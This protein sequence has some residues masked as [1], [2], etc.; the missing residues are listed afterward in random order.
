MDSERARITFAAFVLAAW[1][2]LIT[3][4]AL[5]WIEMPWPLVLSGII[6]ISRGLL[7]LIAAALEIALAV[8]Q[9]KI[10]RAE[11]RLDRRIVRQAKA[12]GI[13]GDFHALGGRALE[14]AAAEWVGLLREDGETDAAFRRRCIEK[15]MEDEP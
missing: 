3:A 10:S 11:R 1:G 8:L 13:W 7:L 9:Y 5:G 12:L 15:M 6:W 2:A 4:R 14:L